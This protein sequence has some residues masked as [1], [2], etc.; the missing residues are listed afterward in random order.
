VPP[1]FYSGPLWRKSGGALEFSKCFAYALKTLL[2]NGADIESKDGHGFTPLYYACASGNVAV[3]NELMSRGAN[4]E[5]KDHV[6]GVPYSHCP[7]IFDRWRK[8]SCSQ[9]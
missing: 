6:D 2:E 8:H 7:G 5:A 1:G 4:T 9:Q 3:V